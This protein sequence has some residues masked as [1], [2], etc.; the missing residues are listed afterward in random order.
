MYK[1]VRERP[2]L[3]HQGDTMSLLHVDTLPNL[4]TYQFHNGE[5]LKLHD[6][7]RQ[8]KPAIEALMQTGHIKS[9]KS[10]GFAM[11]P[12]QWQGYALD[13]GWNTPRQ[14]VWFVY[15]WGPERNRYIANAVRKLRPLVREDADSTLEMR[16]RKPDL[17][18]DVVPSTDGAGNFPWGD[19]GYGGAVK[20][21]VGPLILRGG[22]S[23]FAQIEDDAAA[24]LLLG[25]LGNKILTG[26]E[27]L[28]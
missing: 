16:Y 26:E 12:L 7:L 25:L 8:L 1:L 10:F 18:R 28:P 5:L 22:I 17:F 23:C 3:E 21:K 24:R 2:G 11:T 9:T 13:F 6:F 27:L 19:F 20:A 14:L 4:Q 15:G